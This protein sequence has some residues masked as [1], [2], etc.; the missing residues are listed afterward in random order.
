MFSRL[1]TDDTLASMP[2]SGQARCGNQS[3]SR[4]FLLCSAGKQG[5]ET[6]MSH[7]GQSFHR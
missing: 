7:C 1:L 3:D 2:L 5:V 4:S 6:F